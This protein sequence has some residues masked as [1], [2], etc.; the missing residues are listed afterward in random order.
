MPGARHDHR[1]APRGASAHSRANRARS[2]PAFD[3]RAT[4]W[5]PISAP[6]PRVRRGVPGCRAGARMRVRL[7]GSGAGHQPGDSGGDHSRGG[8]SVNTLAE[9]AASVCSSQLG[10]AGF[11]GQGAMVGQP[12]PSQHD[13]IFWRQSWHRHAERSQSRRCGRPVSGQST[14]SVLLADRTARPVDTGLT[15]RRDL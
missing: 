6:T 4:G 13:S 5:F 2:D 12:P 3:P 10:S 15:A 11:A 8:T 1:R 9:P 14:T 7:I